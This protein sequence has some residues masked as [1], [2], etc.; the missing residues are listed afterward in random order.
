MKILG[1]ESSC[2]E[3]AVSI[4]N[5]GTEILSNYVFS[6]TELHAPFSGVVPEIASRNHL[7]TILPILQQA[8]EHISLSEIDAIA[9]TTGPGLIGSLLIGSTTARTLAYALNKPFIPVDHIDAHLYAPHLKHQIPF[10]HIALVCSGGHTLLIKV[11]SHTNKEIMGTTLDDA[12][13][14]AFDK[15][16]KMLDLG[17]PGGP[18]IEKNALL[19]SE[20]F[21]DLPSDLAN[22]PKDRYNFSYSG[23]KTAVYYKIKNL[24]KPYPINDICAS[25]QKAAV[26]SLIKKLKKIVSDTKISTIITVGGVA[27]NKKLQAELDIFAEK[28]KLKIYHTPIELC[29]DNAAMVAGRAFIDL[30]N[31]LHKNKAVNSYTRLPLIKKGQK[32]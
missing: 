5:Q 18:I 29:G 14:E 9:A 24:S 12:V 20:D 2:D 21:W 23:L 25:F 30:T 32:P 10:P 19:G 3:C 7:K 11:N 17:Y 26:L 28:N 4:V 6:Q 31:N 22:N 8:V 27:A 15:V 1:I 13:G 16:A